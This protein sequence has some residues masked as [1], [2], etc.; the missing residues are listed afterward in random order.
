MN[1]NQLRKQYLITMIYRFPDTIFKSTFK[2]K[3]GSLQWT[4][5]KT[6]SQVEMWRLNQDY[7]NVGRLFNEKTDELVLDIDMEHISEAVTEAKKVIRA[8]N[9][10]KIDKYE[11]YFSG[12][13]SVHFHLRFNFE[14][15]KD[16]DRK[17][18]RQA[19]FEALQTDAK[20]IDKSLF[21][22]T[23]TI[24]VPGFKHR[25]T[26]N[27]KQRMIIKN[28]FEFD[29]L[30]INLDYLTSGYVNKLN[31]EF[32][33]RVKNILKG[34]VREVKQ[35]HLNLDIKTNFDEDIMKWHLKRFVEVYQS[36]KD[37]H[38]R[39]LDCVVRYIYLTTKNL[40]LT[41]HIFKKYCDN[42]G[43]HNTEEFASKRVDWTIQSISKRIENNLPV[44]IFPY[45]DVLTK[46]D[47][48]KTYGGIEQ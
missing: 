7:A 18:V 16:Y 36:L 22:T 31:K 21:Q 6:L 27:H 41:K 12:N 43:I 20:G 15:F 42:I 30:T 4:K 34:K 46:K 38:K 48:Y 25:V 44:A 9:K 13:K 5:G 11:T 37:G 19:F 45:E 26:E 32:I 33:E 47:F 17:E 2:D 3:T 8:L 1:I 24:T 39:L 14:P 10:N 29:K 40:T 35:V 28:D 23:Q